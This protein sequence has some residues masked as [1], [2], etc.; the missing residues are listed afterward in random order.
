MKLKIIIAVVVLFIAGVFCFIRFSCYP[1]VWLTRFIFSMNPYTTPQNYDELKNNIEIVRDINYQSKYKTGFLDIIKPKVVTGTEKL[2]FYAHG[3][4]FVEGD[5]TDVE[6][7]FVM[8]ANEGFV[9]LNINYALAPEKSH[10]PVPVKQ[11]Q[12]A[13]T[14]IKA[15][16]AQYSLNMNDVYFAG[17]SA[18][19]QLAAQ[20]V[21]MQTNP[22][23]LAL[24]NESQKVQF[25]S[26]VDPATIRGVL[27]FC[28]IYNFEQMINP[29]PDTIKLPLDKLGLAYFKNINPKNINITIAGITDKVTSSF[30]RSFITDGNTNSFEFQA[31][32][33]VEK[34]QSLQVPVDSVFYSKDEAQL[35]HVYQFFMDNPYAQKTYQKVL[36]FLRE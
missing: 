32:E 10:Y 22:A 5:K 28:A 36:D 12:E 15:R 33:I 16:Y 25:A 27:L 34:L 23:Y 18:G 9:T 24:V 2:I 11:L 17:D 21:A 1:T 7:Y 8:L 26:V 29:P 13:Y 19:G 6:H 14:F 35:R 20:F 4:A 3:G 31:K 30:P